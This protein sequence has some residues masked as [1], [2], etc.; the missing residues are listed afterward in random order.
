M[1]LDFCNVVGDVVDNVHVQ[2]IRGGVKGLGKCLGGGE[3]GGRI[4]FLHRGRG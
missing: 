3:E 4:W 2:V 1:F